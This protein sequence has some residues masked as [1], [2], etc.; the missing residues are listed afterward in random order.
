MA[1]LELQKGDD[2]YIIMVDKGVKKKEPSL[3]NIMYILKLIL[4]LPL[5]KLNF[6]IVTTV[7]TGQSLEPG[8][9]C[10]ILFH[11]L[12]DTVLQYLIMLQSRPEVML[13]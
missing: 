2:A 9:Q 4:T 11:I 10:A 1:L 7:Q 12:W 8:W 13:T 3:R 5:I 6:T